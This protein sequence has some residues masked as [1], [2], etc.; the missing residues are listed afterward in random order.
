MARLNEAITSPTGDTLLRLNSITK[1]F[2][3]E[4]LASLASEGKLSLNDTLQRFS[5]DK[6]APSF[7]NQPITLLE[8]AT[9]TA[10]L[11]REMGSVPEGAIPRAC[12]RPARNGGR[13]V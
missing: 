10:A 2:T 7:G 5:G 9:D 1:V 12:H 13:G 11:P 4:V 6:K 3:T 8:L